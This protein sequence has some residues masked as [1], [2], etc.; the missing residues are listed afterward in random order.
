MA[1]ARWT[2]F[3]ALLLAG[4]LT[5]GLWPPRSRSA[6]CFKTREEAF[7][8]ALAR[9]LAAER[10]DS[11][12]DPYASS[13]TR[14]YTT[15]AGAKGDYFL[16]DRPE[17]ELELAEGFAAH[18]FAREALAHYENLI[19]FYPDSPQGAVAR[20]RLE[21]CRNRTVLG[22]VPPMSVVLRDQEGRH[23][24]RSASRPPEPLRLERIEQA[25]L[26]A[27]PGRVGPFQAVGF[28]DDAGSVVLWSQPHPVP[29]DSPLLASSP[30]HE[31][32][33]DTG[34]AYY[35]LYSGE[36][37]FAA[38]RMA[39]GN[40]FTQLEKQLGPPGPANAAEYRRAAD[41]MIY[42][43]RR[44]E[45]R[46]VRESIGEPIR[47]PLDDA[48][49]M[50]AD[51]RSPLHLASLWALKVRDNPRLVLSTPSAVTTGSEL[52]LDIEVAAISSL[53]FSF[54]K[55][56]GPLPST[57]PE[58]RAWLERAGGTPSHE[59]TLPVVP[60][61]S[62]LKLPLRDVG[63]Y[64]VTA[65]ARG[66]S[67]SFFAVRSDASLE[68]LALPGE[69]FLKAS[70][71][72]FTIAC[73]QKLLG[74]SDEDGILVPSGAIRA[75]ICAEHQSCCS[76]CESCDHHHGAETLSSNP[77]VF[78]SGRGQFFRATAKIDVSEVAKIAAP[79]PAPLLFVHTDRPVYKAGDTLRFRGVLRVPKMPLQRR[80][81]ARMLPGTGRE[82][83]VAV[84]CGE[85]ALFTRTYVTGDRGTFQ[86]EFTLPLTA[87]RT[88]YSLAVTCEGS[89]I[90]RPFEVLDYRKSDYA[91][92]LTPEA[93]GFRVQAGYVWGSPVPESTLQAR[94]GDRDVAI[95][96]DL[97]PAAD[98]QTVQVAL[99]RGT[100]ELARKMEKYRAPALEEPALVV[101]QVG[102][103]APS[104]AA[105]SADAP[106][107]PQGEDPETPR[108]APFTVKTDKEIYRRG[109]TIEIQ[110]EGPWDEGDATVLLADLQVYDLVRVPMRNGRGTAR[111]AARP[112]HDPGVSVFALMDDRQAR[113]DIRVRANRMTVS[114]DAPARS[115]PGEQVEVTVRSA[116]QAAFA[117][118][119]VDEA[120]YMVREDDTPEI[121]SFFHP[122]RPAALAY[123]RFDHFE[124]DGASVKIE[125]F[126]ADPSFLSGKPL[127]RRLYRGNGGVYEMVGMGSGGGGGGRYV[128]RG[129]ASR[130]TESAVMSSLKALAQAQRTD[131]SWPCAFASEAGTISDVGATG[132][133][134][135]SYLG[136]G[137]SQLSKD[138]F[139]DSLSPG[140]TFK[141]GEIVKK[142]LQWLIS[143]QGPDGRIGGP[144]GDVTLN[145]ALATLALSEA[146]GMTASP[147]LK[148]PAQ[149]ALDHLCAQQ[150]GNGGWH[151]AESRRNGELLPTVFAVMA[152]KSAQLS[153]L[154]LSGHA[155][156][157]ALRFLT[158]SV[159][160]NGLRGTAPTRA[161]VAGTALARLFLRKSKDSRVT[162]AVQW[163]TAHPPAWDQSD[164]LGWYFMSLALFQYDGP[165]G[166]SWRAFND[167]LKAMM[168]P[169][170]AKAGNWTVK[171]ETVYHTALGTL[172]MEV[173][174]RYANVFGGGGG[175]G[176][177]VIER[178]RS[179][180][181]EL[182]PAPRVRVYFPDT[183][184]W[185][186]EMITDDK[187]EARVSFRLPEQITTTRLTARGV[188][189]EGAAGEAVAR[190]ETE[191]PFFVKIRAPEFAV[192]GDDVEIRVEIYNYTAAGLEATVRLEG[193]A[194]ERKALV[195]TDRPAS[196]SWKVRATDP[197]RLR[198]VAHA[199]SAGARDSMERSI[200]VQRVGRETLA[201]LRGKS[202]TG[203]TYRFEAPPGVRDLA[204][205][206]HPRA[207]NLTQVLDALRYLNT[208]PHGCTEQTLAKFVPNVLT[209]D[210][211]KR[212]KIP[213]E[214]FNA[215]FE[216]MMRAGTERLLQ[217]QLASGGWGWFERDSENSFMTAYAVY[218][219]SE[220]ARLG[221]PVDRTALERGRER[222]RVLARG[223]EDL[224]KLAYQAYVLGE[225]FDRLLAAQ[226]RLTS[227]AQALLALGLVRAGRPEAAA[228]A[229]AL[230][231]G[232]RTDH[233]ETPAW[234][235]KW[236]DVTIET[237]AYAL[238]ALAA[239]EPRSPIIPKATEWLLS[240]RCGNR[241]RS[242]KDT[243]V[244]IATLLEVTGLGG[245][246]EAVGDAEPRAG[247]KSLL[248]KIGVT[249]NGGE[250]REILVDLCN[251]TRS[252][253][254]AHFDRVLPGS[255]VLEF[256]KLDEHS[257]FRFELE[258]T[259][260]LFE[261]KAQAE[262]DG[263]ELRVTYDRP[264]EGLRLGDEVTASIVVTAPA[265]VDYLMIQSPIPAGCEIVRGSGLGIFVGFEDRYEK[266]VFFV[267]SV[268]G[269]GLR[270]SYTMRC[271][272]AGNFTVL[273]AWA[274]I[275]YN[276]DV[277]A[278][279]APL[280]AGIRN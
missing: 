138:E 120:I 187:G 84:R 28:V 191:Q 248:K 147:P 4:L 252:V 52:P 105:P 49:K 263:L 230:A 233:W 260:R 6:S 215:S 127:G 196:V 278:T 224:N 242:T 150:S 158:E 272:F 206:I 113:A 46:T 152:L 38:E 210:M 34:P 239:V 159:D 137:Y 182:A 268:D 82:V 80:D 12:G 166:R 232:V 254:E 11:A 185:S 92:V 163:L 279:T 189:K 149:A 167:P 93:R 141:M 223:E 69:S 211:L 261:E 43:G 264:L 253:F 21:E 100:E 169:N 78:V 98:G 125:N 44:E 156:P 143:Q 259:K 181:P 213:T 172:M 8:Y 188:T 267:R 216:K 184:C 218:G 48:G 10:L 131:G 7:R 15:I 111:V 238:Q 134:L 165:E 76:G 42:V 83:A 155:V 262:S 162:G 96:G 103:S 245:V 81:P 85:S 229:K 243:A 176:V 171:N 255:N 136:A 148:D 87:Y 9:I 193:A 119:A 154:T 97:I 132:L 51:P 142:A 112:I 203:G 89:R 183:A 227:Y 53:K 237:T 59:L 99:V 22:L 45:A 90:S 160:E 72:G 231:A 32:A 207:G 26:D 244:A 124:F 17:R 174:Y 129:G 192:L 201:T 240:K 35:A 140:R 67:C 275:M 130:A 115:R 109:E 107:D 117:L 71:P 37:L 19:A 199:V 88:E 3:L 256:H 62:S 56:E 247:E 205:K 23:F 33:V 128:A 58:L 235:Y 164:F 273:P 200:P 151:R 179:M 269:Q 27:F 194:E 145:H 55:L 13:F 144:G 258:L 178:A 24:V 66:L 75:R 197:S 270:L 246:A 198:L 217:L 116:P 168:I 118:S 190:I 135:L 170:Q 29:E 157:A 280:K 250:R 40:L 146:Y 110:V 195:P 68:L 79:V 266:A 57:E 126:P 271:A 225:E 77:T 274:G 121:Y 220:C 276:E 47:D 186:P 204:V 101:K 54:A 202:E 123:G 65:E 153:E 226:D 108:I 73:G 91:I 1:R 104:P 221:F 173:Y 161:E 212:L 122:A 222:L 251:P 50:A 102:P 228:V 209:A 39:K 63:S 175:G 95:A 177:V 106:A 114:V 31:G 60:G 61:K 139:V 180:A 25:F 36:S 219:L 74:T 241:W 257:D 234:Y 41:A 277:H 18:G 2:A 208:Y 64:R 265:P 94:V 16:V 30:F 214:Q 14:T 133:A 236:E 70:G 20:N 86:G 249:L 5:L